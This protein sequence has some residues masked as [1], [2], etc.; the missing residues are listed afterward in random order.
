MPLRNAKLMPD[1]MTI[2]RRSHDPTAPMLSMA[3]D[4]SSVTH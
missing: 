1:S 2:T 3:D 4:R